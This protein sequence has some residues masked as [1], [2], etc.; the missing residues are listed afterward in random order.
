V[1][2][3]STLLLRGFSNETICV[4]RLLHTNKR[5]IRLRSTNI[6]QNLAI[7]DHFFNKST[8]EDEILL[9]WQNSPCVVIGRHQNPWSE[10][11]L[12]YLRQHNIEVARRNSGGGA[13]YHDLQ[14]INLTF[15]TSKDKYNRTKNLECICSALNKI[16]IETEIND[17]DDILMNGRKV[18]G[19]AAKLT[20]NGSYHHCT[21][22]I[23]ANRTHLSNALKNPLADVIKTN[24]TKSVRSP[25]DNLVNAAGVDKVSVDAVI[26]AVASQYDGNIQIENLEYNQN[27]EISKTVDQLKSWNWVYGK[28]PKFTVKDEIIVDSKA[29]I[30]EIDVKNGCIDSIKLDDNHI[31]IDIKKGVRFESSSLLD[32][33][34]RLRNSEKQAMLQ[35]LKKF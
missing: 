27:D 6:F 32:I 2:R 25:V 23:N 22:L 31:E 14:N 18:S 3:K 30:I 29:V 26:D 9:L 7:E 1:T 35:F 10:A 11:N 5:I 33:A 34:Q 12:P 19:T 28:T 20:R 16:G 13:V 21:L 24:A 8:S 4:Q 15:I 17:R